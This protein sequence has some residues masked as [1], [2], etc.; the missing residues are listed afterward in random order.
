MTG[1]QIPRGYG[2]SGIRRR[3]EKK[4]REETEER[5]DEGEEGENIP[6]SPHHYPLPLTA[7]TPRETP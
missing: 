5:S 1:L 6:V 7:R 4:Q 3:R 2:R